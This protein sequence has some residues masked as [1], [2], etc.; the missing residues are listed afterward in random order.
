MTDAKQRREHVRQSLKW[1]RLRIARAKSQG[2]E[3]EAKLWQ[4]ALAILARQDKALVRVR[5]ENKRMRKALRFFLDLVDDSSGIDGFHL[6]GDVA[7]WD[8]F[9][10]EIDNAREVVE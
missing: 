8:E 9:E 4:K 3:G 1:I 10:D 5:T 7:L 2:Q 6:N